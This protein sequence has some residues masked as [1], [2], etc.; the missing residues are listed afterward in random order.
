MYQGAGEELF[1]L[2]RMGALLIRLILGSPNHF[3]E[4]YIIIQGLL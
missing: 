3:K 1:G 4:G 2:L